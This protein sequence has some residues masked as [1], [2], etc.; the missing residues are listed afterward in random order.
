LSGLINEKI[1]EATVSDKL[2]SI[3]KGD[4]IVVDAVNHGSEVLGKR[5]LVAL[6]TSDLAEEKGFHD[7]V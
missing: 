2:V 4:I 7:L 3:R 5:V 1:V 6:E